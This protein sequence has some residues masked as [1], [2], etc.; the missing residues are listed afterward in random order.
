MSRNMKSSGKRSIL[1]LTCS[2]RR[3][4]TPYRHAELR[5]RMT[6]FGH[7]VCLYLSQYITI[8]V[9]LNLKIHKSCRKICVTYR[10]FLPLQPHSVYL[11]AQLYETS[12]AKTRV[13]AWH[14][15][16]LPSLLFARSVS[17]QSRWQLPFSVYESQYRI[18][19]PERK[20]KQSIRNRRLGSYSRIRLWVPAHRLLDERRR[21]SLHA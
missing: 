19:L 13:V 17:P 20:R 11:S 18:Y 14:L 1:R 8:M 7:C 16:L 12:L 9:V 6:C 21:T 2:F 15:M 4:S 5:S 10:L 3:F